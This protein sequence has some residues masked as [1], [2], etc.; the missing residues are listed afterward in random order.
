MRR[1]SQFPKSL[2]RKYKAAI[3]T[4]EKEKSAAAGGLSMDCSK[5]IDFFVEKQRL[6]ASRWDCS[7][8]DDRCLLYEFCNKV[9]SSLS[10]KDIEYAIENLH[11][12]SRENPHK[13]YAQDF[14]EKFPKANPDKEGVPRMCRANCYGGSCQYP[15]CFRVGRAPCKACWNEEMEAA[16]DE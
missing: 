6:C 2:K 5:T 11:K 10:R 16:D 3:D 7:I 15:S 12:W 8:K 9:A 14:F 13:T 4:A 1:R